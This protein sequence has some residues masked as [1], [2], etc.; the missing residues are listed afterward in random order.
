MKTLKEVKNNKVHPI[1]LS[2]QCKGQ[3]R[4]ERPVYKLIKLHKLLNIWQWKII[5]NYWNVLQRVAQLKNSLKKSKRKFDG[6]ELF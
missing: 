4:W 1:F 5:Y 6:L 3:W 2:T